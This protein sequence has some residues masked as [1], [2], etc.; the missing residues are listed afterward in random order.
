MLTSTYPSKEQR[1]LAYNISYM[2][3]QLERIRNETSPTRD[4]TV[5]NVLLVSKNNELRFFESAIQDRAIKWND[6][7]SLTHVNIDKLTPELVCGETRLMV[8]ISKE[9]WGSRI[10]EEST[11]GLHNSLITAA[12]TLGL[13]VHE[14]VQYV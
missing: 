1:N 6:K 3:S 10:D 7:A 11:K 5:D 8:I 2:Y 12:A 13:Q 4:K 9:L 14:L